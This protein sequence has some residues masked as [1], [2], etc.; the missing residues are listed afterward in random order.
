MHK[1]NKKT[2][3]S[4]Q[5]RSTVNTNHIYKVNNT[6]ITL[7]LSRKWSVWHSLPMRNASYFN[8][9]KNTIFKR[10]HKKTLKNRKKT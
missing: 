10:K 1:K 3:V 2:T 5:V 8:N 4:I 7:A 6:A 9:N